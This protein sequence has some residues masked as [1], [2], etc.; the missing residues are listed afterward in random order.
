MRFPLIP[1]VMAVVVLAPMFG[2]YP[3]FI[4]AGCAFTAWSIWL[5]ARREEEAEA[6]VAELRRQAEARGFVLPPP[7]GLPALVERL[8]ASKR[9]KR[10]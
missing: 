9:V 1:G 4:M 3:L 10:G 8:R 7:E 2:N 6:V 5:S